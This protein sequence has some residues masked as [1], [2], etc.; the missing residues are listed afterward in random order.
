MLSKCVTCNKNITK[1]TPGLECNKCE[2]AVHGTTQCAN[3]TAKQL[4]ALR[5]AESLEWTCQDCLKN[6][7]KRA[8]LI[9]AETDSDD[10]E[11]LEGL[12]EKPIFKKLLKGVEKTIQKEMKTITGTLDFFSE[13]I[14]EFNECLQ[15]CVAKM[16][17][18][19]KKN[20]HLINQNVNLETR[21]NAVEQ[22]VQELEQKQLSNHIEISGIAYTE[23]VEPVSIAKAVA[24]QLE[25]PEVSVKAARR[26]NLR[27]D[28][29]GVLL[30][31]L[32]EEKRAQWLNKAKEKK[33][34]VQDLQSTVAVVGDPK[35]KIYI[36]EALTAY[37]KWLMWKVKA[38]LKESFKFIWCKDGL[39]KVR[40]DEK[41]KI[42][43]VR[44]ESDI[45]K[46]IS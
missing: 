20:A 39:I 13:K 36:R 18:L 2:K 43:I 1:K 32:Q 8:S 17:D 40:K 45:K 12:L 37:N 29:V 9:N 44:N 4:A 11:D 21:L 41:S 35:D 34:T 22:R 16:K 10:E 46:L 30:V 27:A 5:S 25:V 15:A 14:D 26:T 7:S 38:E 3:L 28:K 42:L 6:F 23:K 33:L 19:E 31:E 24:K